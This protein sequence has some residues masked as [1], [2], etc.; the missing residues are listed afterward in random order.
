MPPFARIALIPLSGIL[1]V[2][3]AVLGR[4]RLAAYPGKQPGRLADDL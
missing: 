2:G 4:G 1:Y 3:L